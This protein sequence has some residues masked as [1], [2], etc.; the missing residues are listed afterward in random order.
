M[1]ILN[2]SFNPTNTSSWAGV[3]VYW[4]KLHNKVL[5]RSLFIQILKCLQFL[6]SAT[7][8]SI[9]TQP[10]QWDLLQRYYNWLHSS[11]HINYD[12]IESFWISS[13]LPCLKH[14]MDDPIK[15]LFLNL[16]KEADVCKLQLQRNGSILLSSTLWLEATWGLG[17]LRI[18][19]PPLRRR[20][21]LMC[22]CIAHVF[23]TYVFLHYPAHV[24]RRALYYRKW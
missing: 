5:W 9:Y 20:F 11:I 21:K 13:L 10:A 16:E 4:T 24:L 6:C 14:E 8:Q 23:Q 17:A 7:D 22:F 2:K 19:A 3:K 18:L 12:W 15:V 1:T